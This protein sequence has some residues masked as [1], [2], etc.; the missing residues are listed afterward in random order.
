[1]FA[2][3]INNAYLTAK[4]KAAGPDAIET[5]N[6]L[7]LKAFRERITSKICRFFGDVNELKLI[8]F[9]SLANLERNEDL[10]G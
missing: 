8:V 9:E 1:M 4:V 5:T 6:G 2:A 7:L 10:V 3:V